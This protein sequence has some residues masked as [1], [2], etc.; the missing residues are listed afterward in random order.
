MSISS[1][2]ILAEIRQKIET[3]AADRDAALQRISTLED[4]ISDLQAELETTRNDLHR[5]RLDVEFLTVSHRLADTPE[6][7]VTARKII[8]G[9]IRKVD[10]AINLVKNDPAET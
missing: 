9:L 8:S 4:Q 10:S 2:D 6:A 5:A 7:V 3:L 1:T